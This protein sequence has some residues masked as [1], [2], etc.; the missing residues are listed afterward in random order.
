MK[1]DGGVEGGSCKGAQP[2]VSVDS[3]LWELDGT[4]DPLIPRSLVEV[5][6]GSVLK[7]GS[8]PLPIPSPSSGTV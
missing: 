2:S 5:E 7:E 8:D 1:G 3:K 4:Q 6:E